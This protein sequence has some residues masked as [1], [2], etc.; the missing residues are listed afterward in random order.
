MNTKA[1][2]SNAQATPEVKAQA[3]QAF[4]AQV[5][6]R[7]LS[8]IPSFKGNGKST[9]ELVQNY[10]NKLVNMDTVN[11]IRV[12][13]TVNDNKNMI[14]YAGGDSVKL[15]HINDILTANAQANATADRANTRSFLYAY[16]LSKTIT[17]SKSLKHCLETYFPNLDYSSTVKCFKALEVYARNEDSLAYMLSFGYTKLLRLYD[18]DT[19]IQAQIVMNIADGLIRPDMSVS[20]IVGLVKA[21]KNPADKLTDKGSDKGSD[22]LTVAQ[23]TKA[24]ES[25]STDELKAIQAVINGLLTK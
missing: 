15:T 3:T 12:T 9:L 18:S 16:D 22:K 17:D 2:K 11:P 19:A 13:F 10:T 21:L 20:T 1:T 14:G 5:H 23:V 24:L 4:I 8:A 6:G 7:T 25:F